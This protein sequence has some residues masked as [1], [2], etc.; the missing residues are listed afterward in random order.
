MKTLIR[1]FSLAMLF[2]LIS[3]AALAEELPYK[4]GPVV[5]IT[6]IRTKDGKFL[7]YWNFLSTQ[8][9]KEMDEAKKRG[10]V[11]S[12]NVYTALPRTPEDPDLFLV[13]T[14]ANMAAFD[15]LDEK[16][17]AIDAAIW[18]SLKEAAQ[19]Q[20]DR[21]AIRTVIGDQIMR[22]LMFK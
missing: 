19:K 17:S 14:Y 18:G 7:D 20:S 11:V 10:L 2:A 1:Q 6:S 3:G 9:K 13:V 4:E 12:Y 16:M 22:E 5:D 21:G 8:W 15:G